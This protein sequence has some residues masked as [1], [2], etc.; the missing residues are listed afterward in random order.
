MGL[1]RILIRQSNLKSKASLI[2]AQLYN[3][4]L[5]YDFKKVNEK[6][7]GFEFRHVT[8]LAYAYGN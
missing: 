4:V 6:N 1:V 7:M 8:S 5:E 2:L 3:L